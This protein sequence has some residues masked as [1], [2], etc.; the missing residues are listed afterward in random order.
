MKFLSNLEM[1]WKLFLKMIFSKDMANQ[2]INKVL[3][4]LKNQMEII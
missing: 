2:W 1:I 3:T 4:S